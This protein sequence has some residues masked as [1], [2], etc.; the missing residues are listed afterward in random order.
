MEGTWEQR[1]AARAAL[2]N[3]AEVEQE[4]RAE[5]APHEGHH[6]HLIGTGVH[7]SCGEFVGITTVAFEVD[8]EGNVLYEPP[9]CTN[10]GADG[11]FFGMRQ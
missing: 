6:L 1:M 4:R 8:D 10:C 9:T 3:K 2:R 5:V 11:L 7:C